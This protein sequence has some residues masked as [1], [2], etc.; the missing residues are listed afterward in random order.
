MR[1]LAH[2]ILDHVD[3]RLSHVGGHLRVEPDRRRAKHIILATGIE[4]AQAA[5]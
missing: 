1:P 5:E 4:F 3:E 2:D